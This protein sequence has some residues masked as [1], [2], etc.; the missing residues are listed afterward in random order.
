MNDTSAVKTR[1]GGLYLRWSARGLC[2]VDFRAPARRGAHGS[3][4]GG[5]ASVRLARQL[6]SY[7]AGR[8]VRWAVP[9]DLAAGTPFQRR[10]WRALQS[11]PY[12]ETRSYAW[13][14]KQVGAPR[15][16]RAVGGACGANPVPIVVP[17]HRVVRS[18]GQLG[19]FTAGL[20][21]KKRLLALER[22]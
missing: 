6:Q 10:V 1:L 21:W 19:G 15:A 14:A 12:G 11:I 17:C 18:D 22:A 13:V 4:G 7:A 2:G 5:Q 16:V 9:L 20:A 8:R 3:S